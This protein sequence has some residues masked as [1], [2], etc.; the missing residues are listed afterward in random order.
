M[1]DEYLTLGCRIKDADTVDTVRD[2]ARLGAATERQAPS[3]ERYRTSA[4]TSWYTDGSSRT[5]LFLPVNYSCF[6]IYLSICL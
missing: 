4:Y 5:P 1:P 2:P 6:T 3:P